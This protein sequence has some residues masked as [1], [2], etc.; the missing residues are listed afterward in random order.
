MDGKES[1]AGLPRPALE[2][3]SR[4][5]RANRPRSGSRRVP[6][7]AANAL[8]QDDARLVGVRSRDRRRSGGCCAALA[9]HLRDV[10]GRERASRA[11]QNS[12]VRRGRARRGGEGRAAARPPSARRMREPRR[13]GEGGT[14]GRGSRG[15]SR[16]GSLCSLARRVLFGSIPPP[17][18]WRAS[19]AAP[20]ACYASAP[21]RS[22][23]SR[24]SIGSVGSPRLERGTSCMSSKCSNQL[25]YEPR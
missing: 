9:E 21:E 20:S 2:Q 19:A 23:R 13:G 12:A 11:S 14:G 3:E 15:S 10:V 6:R 17:R 8:E 7:V 16:R 25:S 1:G 5:G 4:R 22:R 18:S 24:T